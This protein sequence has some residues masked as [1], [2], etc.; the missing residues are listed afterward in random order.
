M[1][2]IVATVGQ[3]GFGAVVTATVQKRDNTNKLVTLIL[4]AGTDTVTFIFFFD[5]GTRKEFAGVITDGP[6][7][8]CEY[9]TTTGV[10]IEGDTVFLQLQIV[11][12]SPNSDVITKK[13][14][15]GI[16]RRY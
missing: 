4:D 11:R 9:T 13:V 12:A 16:E 15:L 7:G 14:Q 3:G 1:S 5:D 6:N 8:V 2:H 10:I